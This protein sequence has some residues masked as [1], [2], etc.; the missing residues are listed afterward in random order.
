MV[1][2]LFQLLFTPELFLSTPF[3][4]R[5][6]TRIVRGRQYPDLNCSN[7]TEIVLTAAHRLC[8][9]AFE[10]LAVGYPPRNCCGRALF[11]PKLLYFA[12]AAARG[13]AP[14]PLHPTHSMPTW[15]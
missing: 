5:I 6:L 13:E 11:T 9:L 7:L 2:G 12:P 15:R 1:F 4:W 8:R 14:N 10:R 3:L